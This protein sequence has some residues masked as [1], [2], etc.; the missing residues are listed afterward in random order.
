M[1]HLNRF[2]IAPGLRGQGLGTALMEEVTEIA[3]ARGDTRMT[4]YVYG[5]NGPARRLYEKLG[6]QIIGQNEAP[7][8]AS[9]VNLR[10]QRQF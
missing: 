5:S 2:A 3:R 4:L 6:F 7:E 9:G 8:D 10:M 1:A